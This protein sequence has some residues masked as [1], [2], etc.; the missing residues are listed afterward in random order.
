MFASHEIAIGKDKSVI[1]LREEWG[2]GEGCEASVPEAL[3]LAASD[4]K[5]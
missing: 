2:W 3:V 4:E 5:G 1:S